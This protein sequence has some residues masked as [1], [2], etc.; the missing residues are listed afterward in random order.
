MQ[1]PILTQAAGV[2]ISF[3]IST[4]KGMVSDYVVRKIVVVMGD[5]IVKRTKS[6]VDNKFWEIV[7]ESITRR[8][9]G[10]ETPIEKELI[11]EKLGN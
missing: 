1:I 10:N 11:D 3:G 7:R 4:L 2:F 6:D 8:Q 5:E 9:E